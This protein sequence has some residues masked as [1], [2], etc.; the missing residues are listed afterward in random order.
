MLIVSGPS[1]GTLVLLLIYN[2]PD[3]RKYLHFLFDYRYDERFAYA[4]S[5]L[6]ERGQLVVQS[7]VSLL[8]NL[9]DLL[10]TTPNCQRGCKSRHKL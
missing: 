3:V 5:A 9:I 2:H 6:L 8:R 7:Y 4:S 1:S 10:L